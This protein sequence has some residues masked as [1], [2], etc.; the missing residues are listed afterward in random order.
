MVIYC[1]LY[2]VGA[3]MMSLLPP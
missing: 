2:H 1:L 3:L